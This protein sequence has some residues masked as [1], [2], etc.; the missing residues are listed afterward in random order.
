MSK[1]I[2]KFEAESFKKIT[3]DAM[4]DYIEAYYPDDKAW[5]KQVAFQ[6]KD[7]NAVEKYNHLNAARKFCE[8]YAPDLLPDAKEKSIPAN[9]RL[10]DW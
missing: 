2:P 6:D 5:F 3:L 10:K 8:K 4:A 9:E 7:G 1:S